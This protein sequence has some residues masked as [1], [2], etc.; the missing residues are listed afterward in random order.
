LIKESSLYFQNEVEILQLIKQNKL[1]GFP[2]LIDFG[3]IKGA[4]EDLQY[5]SL[6]VLGASISSNFKKT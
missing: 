2:E 3:S 6:D 4:I 5:I 1:K